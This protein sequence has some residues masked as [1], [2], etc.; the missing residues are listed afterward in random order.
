MREVGKA[1]IS[2]RKRRWLKNSRQGMFHGHLI[3]EEVGYSWNTVG[4]QAFAKNFH[5]LAGL[6]QPYQNQLF[7]IELMNHWGIGALGY[8]MIP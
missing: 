4:E 7:Q 5:I 3:L 6:G 2:I 1:G 8:K